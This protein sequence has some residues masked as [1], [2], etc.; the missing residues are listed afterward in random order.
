MMF[1]ALLFIGAPFMLVA[2]TIILSVLYHLYGKLWNTI[3]P[4]N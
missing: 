2:L 4:E 1:Y 3:W